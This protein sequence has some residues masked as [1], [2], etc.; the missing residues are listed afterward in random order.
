MTRPLSIVAAALLVGLAVMF[1]AAARITIPA[2]TWDGAALCG[3]L[4]LCA[5]VAWCLVGLAVGIAR[6]WTNGEEE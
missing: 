4:V 6:A 3:G 5:V 1:G 2:V